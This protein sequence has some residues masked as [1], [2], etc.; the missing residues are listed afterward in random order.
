MERKTTLVGPAL[1][2]NVDVVRAVKGGTLDAVDF[3]LAVASADDTDADAGFVRAVA[4]GAVARAVADTLQAGDMVDVKP[5]DLCAKGSFAAVTARRLPSRLLGAPPKRVRDALEQVRH[6]WMPQLSAHSNLTVGV[7]VAARRAPG[8]RVEVLLHTGDASGLV[9]ASLVTGCERLVG[10]V[11]KVVSVSNLQPRV[12]AWSGRKALVGAADA[13]TSVLEDNDAV[14]AEL[15]AR[16][17]RAGALRIASAS[18]AYGAAKE[19]ECTALF[20]FDA[21]VSNVRVVGGRDVL[22]VACTGCGTAAEPDQNDIATACCVRHG[23]AHAWRPLHLRL[24]DGAAEALTP[25]A[26]TTMLLRGIEPDEAVRQPG[27]LDACRRLLDLV[28]RPDADPIAFRARPPEL[29]QHGEP[30][31]TPLELV[32][33]T[34]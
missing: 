31:C 23:L 24:D 28:C 17:P 21:R 14:A 20:A 16:C 6:E 8:R 18:A 13:E 5:G 11:G 12:R 4:F 32:A 7:V 27:L 15:R 9:E 2:L 33:C 30:V 19:A 3:E 29:D 26:V 22:C 25:S 34:W 1:V 10:S